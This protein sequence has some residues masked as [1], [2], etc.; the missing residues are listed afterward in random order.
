MDI[1][2][3]LERRVRRVN[4]VRT[5]LVMKVIRIGNVGLQVEESMLMRN[6]MRRM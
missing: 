2:C 4:T 5:G 1:V 3:W 6:V